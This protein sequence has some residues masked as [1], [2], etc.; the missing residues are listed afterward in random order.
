MFTDAVNTAYQVANTATGNRIDKG[1]MNPSLINSFDVNYMQATYTLTNAVPQFIKYNRG[2][3]KTFEG[4]IANY[5]KNTCAGKPNGGTL[6]LLTGTSDY[7]LIFNPAVT[8]MVQDP[9]PYFTPF[10]YGFPGIT[11]ILGGAPLVTPRAL[12]TAGCCVW[13]E[14]GAVF[15]YWWPRSEAE[16]FAVMTNNLDTGP[17]LHQTE[18]SVADLEVLLTAPG[19]RRVSLFPGYA[20]CHYPGN[21]VII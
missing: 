8:A 13:Q 10:P 20:A 19:T 18:M 6:Y 7:G 9:P 1:H 14:P 5:A 11:N 3:W 17:D 2:V 21:N 4:R 16:S 12:W 15:G